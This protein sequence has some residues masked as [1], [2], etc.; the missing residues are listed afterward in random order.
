[1][2]YALFP[3]ARISVHVMWGRQKQNTVLA[4]GK[5]ILDR[6][7]PVDLGSI[8]LAHGGGGH[9][10]AATCQVPHDDAERVLAEVVEALGA[11]VPA[12]V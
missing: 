2:V 11:P 6:T 10:A 3:Q 5:S 8:A 9:R 1:M 12:L 4:M 7:S